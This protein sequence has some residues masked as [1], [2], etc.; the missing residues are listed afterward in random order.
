V[1]K[2]WL[3]STCA[4]A[5]SGTLFLGVS[6]TAVADHPSIDVTVSTPGIYTRFATGPRYGYYP[7][8]PAGYYAYALP[9]PPVPVY[10]PGYWTYYPQPGYWSDRH[11]N[12][13]R[14]DHHDYDRGPRHHQDRG[15]DRGRHDQRH[16]TMIE[17]W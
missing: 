17:R 8:P 4:V 1:I 14:G 13:D 15:R 16:D 11:R 2:S 7:Y 9:P 6:S 10:V 3:H 5:A 12:Y